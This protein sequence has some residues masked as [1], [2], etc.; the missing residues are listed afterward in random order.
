[1]NS[2][3]SDS[4]LPF[5]GKH[6]EQISRTLHAYQV[7]VNQAAIVSITDIQGNIIY[8]NEMFIQVSK[9]AREE[10][11][12]KN[13]RIINSSYHGK[14][15]FSKMWQNIKNGKPWRG[16][17]RNKAKDGSYYWVDTVIT[18]IV[19]KKGDIFQYLSIR[20]L[21]TRQK[22][23]E[24]ELVNAQNELRKREKQ[25]NDAQKVAKTGSWYLNVP[26][27][28]HLEWSTET[29][30]I[31]EIEPGTDMTYARFLETVHPQDRDMVNKSWQQAQRT[32]NYNIEHKILTKSGVKWVSERAKFEFDNV[33][34]LKSALGTVQD[35]TAKREIEDSLKESEILYKSL[36]NKSP[37][38][39]GIVDKKTLQFL[40]VNETGT[41]LYGYSREEFLKLSA[42]DIRVEEDH[43][44]LK[45]M[46]ASGHLVDDGSI[47]RHKKKNGEIFFVQP[48]FV[49]MQ[50]KGYD[51]FLVTINDV[52]AKLKIE[53]ELNLAEQKRQ[54][55]ILE[56]EEKSRS[57]IGMELHDNVNQLLV[58]S[59]LY[60]QHV[61][62]SSE[63]SEG[64]LKTAK[65][66]LSSAI[67][68]IRKLSALLV[69]PI[70]DKTNLK[71]SIEYLA[72]G[73]NLL[74]AGIVL[75]INIREESIASDLKTNIYRI[76]Q[77]QLNN[78]MKHAE[79]TK[80]RINLLQ[81]S[82]CLDLEISDNGK[83]FDLKQAQK[84]IGM[85]NIIYR[86][87]AYG[88]KSSITTDI[89]KG[90]KISIRFNLH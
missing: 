3:Y 36:F 19:N 52:T 30:R 17:I 58:S 57:E 85:A 83:G 28:G 78:I 66:I 4:E 88:G 56:A 41:Q 61:H 60:L 51:A 64:L 89:G 35:I 38:A 59:R 23:Y 1:M 71:E 47:K 16:E 26:G 81:V 5:G 44:V 20:N 75:N 73:Y 70:L 13:H 79:A 53:E 34:K 2:G 69:T 43:E 74:N 68:E 37:F 27:E 9:Y 49:S 14:E 46:L 54:K 6:N 11:L 65:D 63:K 86:A 7:A 67:E 72:R 50:Y 31:F 25:L 40:E 62:T 82:N 15:F 77:E 33:A 18:P 12:G 45:K 22:E 55:D 84:G 80:V 48:S 42:F 10:L 21:I 39:I 87:E 32:G 90:C 8:V 29:Y 76:I 24:E